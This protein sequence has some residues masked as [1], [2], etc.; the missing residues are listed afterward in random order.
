MRASSLRAR[1]GSA[2]Q[3][4]EER[5]NGAARNSL[6]APVVLTKNKRVDLA[7]DVGLPVLRKRV[8]EDP[9]TRVFVQVELVQ[10]SLVKPPVATPEE[11][12][13]V[14]DKGQYTVTQLGVQRKPL[15]VLAGDK[16]EG[17]AKHES[18][19][20]RSIAKLP[21]AVP[22]LRDRDVEYIVNS[23]WLQKTRGVGADGVPNLLNTLCKFR[24][25]SLRHVG[26]QERVGDVGI[27]K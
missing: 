5:G 8:I 13:E 1:G 14:V 18:L 17:V 22:I 23:V 9:K 2:L 4:L 15:R 24:A 16:E 12:G 10:Q 25:G 6:E 7:G 21:E 20:K 27:N 26:V 19:A 11:L 3:F